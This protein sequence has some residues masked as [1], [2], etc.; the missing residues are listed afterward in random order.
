MTDLLR[1]TDQMASPAGKQVKS[2]EIFA[3]VLA[4]NDDSGRHGVLI[5]NDVYAFFPDL[6]IP[7]PSVNVTLEFPAFDSV[8]GAELT[9][10]YK[11]YQRYPERRITRLNGLI[12][13]RT[14]GPRLA[15]F[16]H[17]EH[18]DGSSGYY[19]D[20]ANSAPGGRFKK[21]FKLIFGD[22]R[23]ASP[24][25]FIV[26]PIDSAPF[27]EDAVLTE[28]LKLFDS[29]SA[30]GWLDS[31]REGD[32]GIGYTFE[33]LIGIAEN[34]DK[35]A[36]FK[37]IEIKC[38]GLRE[39]QSVLSGKINL[40]Q[41]GPTWVAEMSAKERIRLLGRRSTNGLYQCHSQVTTRPNNLL[42]ALALHNKY[43]RVDLC[44]KHKPVGHWGY[45][46]LATRLTEK[47]SRVIF[48]KAAI[49]KGASG[50]QFRYDEVVYCERPSIERFLKLVRNRNIM[51]EFLMSE[52]PN[53]SVRNH[54]YP[55]RLSKHEYLEHL[56]AYK[57][58]L[59]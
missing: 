57:I 18:M 1:Y 4:V 25:V 51:F 10:G 26:R 8:S 54:G 29:V 2:A 50:T 49:R 17:I 12:N 14:K 5:P 46:T 21:L 23:S 27:T 7:D 28:L 9:L 37:G 22:S 59:R 6:S 34:N 20:C 53:G 13:N 19:F 38:K 30:M 36:D 43:R 58:K 41:A 52:K 45:D 3:K 24:G 32:T 56:F 31:S 47:H 40:F 39:G 16:V 35:I 33:T 11:Y 15:I 48:V 44:K 55:W 42:L